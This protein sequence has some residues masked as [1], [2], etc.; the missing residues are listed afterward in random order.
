MIHAL[1]SLLANA[2]WPQL[3]AEW[4]RAKRGGSA[5]QQPFINQ[6]LGRTWKTSITR[7][8]AACG[9]RERKGS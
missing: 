8:A 1:V 9:A 3:M 4:F 2:T 7:A 6:V 5:E